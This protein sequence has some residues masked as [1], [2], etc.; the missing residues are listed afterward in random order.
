MTVSN[1]DITVSGN[2]AQALST[3]SATYA[4][5][6]YSSHP[7]TN[8]N[9]GPNRVLSGGFYWNYVDLLK[10]DTST[11]PDNDNVTAATLRIFVV[12]VSNAN[13]RSIVGEYF[14]W[15][16]TSG[17]WTLTAPA[18]PVLS[19]PLSS[20][21]AGS[22]SN[23]LPFTDFSGISKTGNTFLR[24][25]ISGGQPTGVNSISYSAFDHATN[26]APRLI[27]THEPGADLVGMAGI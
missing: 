14:T 1:F 3:S 25:H 11:L 12:S 10:F 7:S 17:D 9:I 5:L 20:I 23:D 24:L 8:T 2:D 15:D 4:G 6:A 13:S 27:V 19:V 16:G 18:S 21:T 22:V 26:P